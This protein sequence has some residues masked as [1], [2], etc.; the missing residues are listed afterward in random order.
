MCMSMYIINTKLFSL[1]LMILISGVHV[2]V[3]FE[4][5]AMSLYGGSGRMGAGRRGKTGNYDYYVLI[6]I[7][8]FMEEGAGREPVEGGRR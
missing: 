6:H 8:M 3:N 7:Y 2:Y 5:C 1:L 4:I